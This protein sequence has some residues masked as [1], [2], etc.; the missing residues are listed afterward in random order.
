MVVAR[1]E[2]GWAFLLV[3]VIIEK[4][5]KKKKRKMHNLYC[6]DGSEGH[7]QKKRL[8]RFRVSF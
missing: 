1:E 2:K 5:K 3:Q 8:F 4:K 6:K 7:K